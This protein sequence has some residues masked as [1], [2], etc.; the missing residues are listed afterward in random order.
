MMQ[1]AT[2]I[3]VL[4]V[5]ASGGVATYLFAKRALVELSSL[6]P[7]KPLAVCVA[8]ICFVTLFSTGPVILLPFAV[9][10]IACLLLLIL[11]FLIRQRII[12]WPNPRREPPPAPSRPVTP[13]RGS[14]PT[15]PSGF[16]A[17]PKA[18]AD[19][20]RKRR[21]PL[22]FLDPGRKPGK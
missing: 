20:P 6:G 8:I 16:A 15:I 22:E 13:E 5:A 9:L 19:G 18:P 21:I 17:K 7:P 14:E 11:Q 12:P 10:G 2:Q 4:L 3:G 1:P